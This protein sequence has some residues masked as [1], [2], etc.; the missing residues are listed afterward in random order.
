MAGIFGRNRP[1][2]L[3]PSG[4][5][6]RRSLP[7]WVPVMAVGAALGAGGVVYW[8]EQGPKRLTMA[9]SAAFQSRAERAE[10]E[11][12]R[13]A[14]ELAD[15][16]KRLE[17]AQAEAS[18]ATAEAK[19]ARRSVETLTQDLALV[20]E[21]LPPDQRGGPI[22]VR[23]A[24]FVGEDGAV[25]WRALLT[26]ETETPALAKAIVEIV[27]T[28]RRANGQEATLTSEPTRIGFDGVYLRVQ[29]RIALPDGFTARQATIRVLGS[30]GT[31]V[32]GTR[33]Y[34]VR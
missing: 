11:L 3:E 28:G 29:G 24:R 33:V 22:G 20:A 25:A 4:H 21:Q 7:K 8:Q 34:S 19:A 18:R 14:G 27:L 2:Y 10:D 17:A 32:L 30:D 15:T 1:V 16:R 5:R 12:R 13:T 9:E 26:R 6:R 31:R 23:T